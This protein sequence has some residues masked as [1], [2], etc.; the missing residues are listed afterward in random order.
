MSLCSS[1]CICQLTAYRLARTLPLCAASV[2]VAEVVF[3]A[4]LMSA[5]SSDSLILQVA[6]VPEISDLW[7]PLPGRVWRV[8]RWKKELKKRNSLLPDP[9]TLLSAGFL[10]FCL[11]HPDSG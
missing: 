4:A 6:L 2:A 10:F 1:H 3:S 5:L 9:E 7:R 11:G 8:G